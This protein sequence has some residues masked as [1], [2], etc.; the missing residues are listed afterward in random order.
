[1]IKQWLFLFTGIL[2]RVLNAFTTFVSYPCLQLTVDIWSVLIR[3]WYV[4]RNVSVRDRCVF[5]YV[6]FIYMCVCLCGN[7]RASASV[8]MCVC[9]CVCIREH[10]HAESNVPPYVQS[11]ST[12]R[13]QALLQPQ[14]TLRWER[15]RVFSAV[16]ANMHSAAEP[17]RATRLWTPNITEPKTQG[18][19]RGRWSGWLQHSSALPPIVKNNTLF[20]SLLFSSPLLSPSLTPLARTLRPRTVILFV[21]AFKSVCWRSSAF[22]KTT[23]YLSK[24]TGVTWTASCSGRWHQAIGG[25]F[26]LY[27]TIP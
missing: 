12:K 15:G 14:A 16:V 17:R 9:V 19:P 21:A 22:R 7:V 23:D 26:W 27:N 10:V 4:C 13:C 3:K 5:L 8:D 1:M 6:Q 24:Q 11:V 25:A 18:N 2:K 20:C